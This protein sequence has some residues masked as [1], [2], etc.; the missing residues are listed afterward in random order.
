M[1]KVTG[2]RTLIF[3]GALCAVL[4][5][6][7]WAGH[8]S[9]EDLS[10]WGMTVFVIWATALAAYLFNRRQPVHRGSFAHPVSSST[11]LILSLSLVFGAL[12]GVWGLWFGILVPV[13]VVLAAY[14]AI[15]DRKLRR[16]MIESGAVDPK[17]PPYLA[18]A[19]RPREI[20]RW[21]EPSSDGSG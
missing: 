9:A 21:P 2:A 8:E 10:L 5:I 4:L 14:A 18:R 1:I 19:G 3:W 20:P 16:R 7:C 13:P 17:A 6:L 11:S 12:A 15:R